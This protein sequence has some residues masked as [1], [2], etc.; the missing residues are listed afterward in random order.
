MTAVPAPMP[1]I[2]IEPAPPEPAAPTAPTAHADETADQADSGSARFAKVLAGVQGKN[3]RESSSSS[4]SS[5]TSHAPAKPDDRASASTPSPTPLPDATVS[6]LLAALANAITHAPT[7]PAPPMTATNGDITTPAPADENQ[8]DPLAAIVAKVEG[9]PAIAAI[10]VPPTLPST[11]RTAGAT[12]PTLVDMLREAEAN[13]PRVPTAPATPVVPAVSESV[14][15]TLAAHAAPPNMP[16]PATPAPSVT[17]PTPALIAPTLPPPQP[18]KAA[19][20]VPVAPLATAAAAPPHVELTTP[21]NTPSATAA[22]SAP[23]PPPPAEQLVSVLRPLQRAA[24]GSYQLR[25]ELRP[26]ELG[27]VDLRV[28]LRDGVLHATINAEHPRTAELVR[29]ALDDLRAQLDAD[30]VRAGALNVGSE[31]AG[32]FERDADTP[33]APG[34]GNQTPTGPVTDLTVEPTE[35]ESDSLLDVRL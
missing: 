28:E 9:A 3:G 5:S 30:G 19:P 27:R 14:I 20:A 22:A 12:V 4:S 24:D 8:T 34:A 31:G 16:A 7:T 29:N 15:A 13:A 1:S 11:P 35:S 6:S 32:A 23:A 10:L 18:E 21:V 25:I 26:P 17:T 33:A 2:P